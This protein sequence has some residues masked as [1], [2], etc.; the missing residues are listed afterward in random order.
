MLTWYATDQLY[1]Y[2]YYSVSP[3]S[4]N[5]S[6]A[7]IIQISF[8]FQWYSGSPTWKAGQ[9]DAINYVELWFY[10][11]SGNQLDTEIADGYT[12]KNIN[13]PS[14]SVTIDL[15]NCTNRYKT[16]AASVGVLIDTTVHAG[17]S[18]AYYDRV[19]PVAN[20][21]LETP[22]FTLTHVSPVGAP[23][24]PK[25]S[26]TISRSAVELSWGGKRERLLALRDTG[27][28]LRD[29]VTGQSVLIVDA[30]AAWRLLGLT[31]QQLQK[32]VETV[33]AGEFPGLRL[34]PY[35]TVGQ[36]NGMLA[37][38]RMENVMI[39]QWR[40]STLVAFASAGLD[41][42]GGYRALTGGVT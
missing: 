8:T 25:V 21:N 17:P 7:G 23:S 10:D 28:T 27:N 14:G 15:S 36:S 35:S 12:T 5:V 38:L 2:R 33:A 30:A 29:P 4:G 19:V 41:A 6:D 18:S 37:A 16:T 20:S 39:D 31:R 42:E 1:P 11:A 13:S 26:E 40:G 34:I 9:L 22:R 24:S 32:P 3:I